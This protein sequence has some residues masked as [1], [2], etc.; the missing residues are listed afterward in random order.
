MEKCDGC[1]KMDWLS[2]HPGLNDSLKLCAE[3][4]EADTYLHPSI[5][6]FKEDKHIDRA[7]LVIV[8]AILILMLLGLLYPWIVGLF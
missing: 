4:S 8:S 2:V 6:L 3:C 5:D 1:G 7:M